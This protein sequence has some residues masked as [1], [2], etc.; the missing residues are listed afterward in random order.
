MK[1]LGGVLRMSSGVNVAGRVALLDCAI[2]A[3][4]TQRDVL[5]HDAAIVAKSELV[6]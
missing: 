2:D 1:A 3:R 6:T 4:G 5:P